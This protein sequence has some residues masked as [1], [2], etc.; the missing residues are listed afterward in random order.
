MMT[1]IKETAKNIDHNINT[2]YKIIYVYQGFHRVIRYIPTSE[3]HDC[4]LKLCDDIECP[5]LI[6]NT[7]HPIGIHKCS[8]GWKPCTNIDCVI[9]KYHISGSC[10]NC[11]D[12]KGPY[13]L[14]SLSSTSIANSLPR[15]QS[16]FHFKKR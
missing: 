16:V 5:A 2:Y 12:N 10:K 11:I 9:K 15:N 8:S 13:P 14:P 1:S 6:Y 7:M 3:A 4:Y